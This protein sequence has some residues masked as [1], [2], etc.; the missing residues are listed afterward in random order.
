LEG[1][2]KRRTCHGEEKRN[3]TTD[4]T[5]CTDEE[6]GILVPSSFA[7]L[8]MTA[9]EVVSEFIRVIRVIRG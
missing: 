7:A 6:K 5:D 3:L 1:F 4:Y 8:R 2:K 9:V